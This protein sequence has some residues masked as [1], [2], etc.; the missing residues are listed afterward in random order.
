MAYK[1]QSSYTHT[2]AHHITGPVLPKQLGRVYQEILILR[3]G[4]GQ[5]LLV[6]LW[7]I[8]RSDAGL[9]PNGVLHCEREGMRAGRRGEEYHWESTMQTHARKPVHGG[10]LSTAH[11]L[12]VVR[13]HTHTQTHTHTHTHKYRRAGMADMVA[14]GLLK[15]TGEG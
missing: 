8:C 11:R 12:Q 6:M 15:V 2:H 3:L 9:P 10:I 14:G 13:T 1:C 5:F 4:S 7:S